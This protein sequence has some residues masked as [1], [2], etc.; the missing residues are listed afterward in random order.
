MGPTD[1]SIFAA[2]L[3]EPYRILGL[4]L[5]PFSL[6][7]YVILSRH[8]SAFVAE[9]EG[10]ATR[11]DL[12]FAVLV[13]S[14]SF[15]EFNEWID[16]GPLPWRQKALAVFRFITSRSSLAELLLA[17]RRSAAEYHVARWGRQVGVFDLAEKAALF[18]R[19]VDE[20]SALP[21]YWEE[22]ESKPS[23]GHWSQAVFLTLTGELGFTATQA[24][25]MGL[26]EA[27]LHFFKHAESIGA[28]R[29]MSPEELEVVN[30]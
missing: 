3:P 30:G 14:M 1:N 11:E 2:A 22:K 18:K 27:F 24:W 26:R 15:E 8:G 6:G 9:Q 4:K 29:L 16:S 12:I 23:G 5:R 19:Y 17:L 10:R 25:N 21:K 20:H 13:C 7:H 28:V